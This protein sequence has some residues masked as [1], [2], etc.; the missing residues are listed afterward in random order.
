MN[1]QDPTMSVNVNTT[2]ARA[3]ALP[4]SNGAHK[5]PPPQST[6]QPDADS[7]APGRLPQV[8]REL[9]RHLNTL[10]DDYHAKV[11]DI[12]RRRDEAHSQAKQKL[13]NA[14]K[15]LTKATS[16]LDAW[17]KA[18]EA[19]ANNLQ[20][21][22]NQEHQWALGH[23]NEQS[24]VVPVP[25]NLMGSQP[26]VA[27]NAL[28]T[29]EQR[30][31]SVQQGLLRNLRKI[32]K[33]TNAGQLVKGFAFGGFIL[34]I[35]IAVNSRGGIDPVIG[36]AFVGAI[37]GGVVALV[38]NLS[39]KSN[40]SA[41]FELWLGEKA[42]IE[43]HLTGYHQYLATARQHKQAAA[44]ERY[45]Q[46]K[47]NYEKALEAANAAYASEL[48]GYNR[49]LRP[50]LDKARARCASF[51]ESTAF[52]GLSWSE[53]KWNEWQPATSS[54]FSSCLG[55]LTTPQTKMLQP[56]FSGASLDF[57]VSALLPFADGQDGR[58]LLM[59][60]TGAAKEDATKAIQSVMLRLLANIP[61]GKVLFTLLDPVGL[62][63][64]VA[65]FMPLAD[66]EEKLI[67]SR[68]WTEPQH[69]EE[70]LSKITEHM[71]NVIQKYL[72]NDYPT[73]EEYNKK[74]GEVAEPYRVLVALDF[75][76]N[77]S[78]SAARRLV[79][80][81]RNGPRCGVYTLVVMDTDPSKKS[82]YGFNLADL[83]QSANVIVYNNDGAIQK[84]EKQNVTQPIS[85]GKSK[86]GFVWKDKELERYSLTLDEAP[87]GELFKTIIKTVGEKSKDA[88]KV[89]V[90]FD[91]LLT[92]AG[93]SGDNLWEAKTHDMI[94]VPLGPKGAQKLQYLTFGKGTEHHA[95]VI[96]MPGSGKSNLMHIIITSMAMMYSPEE[97]QLYLIDFK[98]GVEFKRYAE[99]RLPHAK[100]IAIES[101]REFGLSVL[102][103]LDEEL[104]R[105]G[106]N[107]RKLGVNAINEYR[108][109]HPDEKL[110]RILL[111][112]DE[113]QEFFSYDDNIGREANLLL[114]RL[115]RQGR[116]AGIHVM[117][118]SQ[119]LANRSSL[120][121]STL[122]QVGIR[123][124][125]KCSESDARQ[126]MADDNPQ[127]RLLSRSG[128]AIYN[129]ASG[130]IEGNNFFQVAL[131]TDEDRRARL[132][133]ITEF[134]SKVEARNGKAFDRPIIFEGNEPSRL[135]ECAPLKDLLSQNNYPAPKKVKEL[136][137][138]EPVAIRPPTSA[139][140]RQQGASN[141]LIV[142]RNEEEGVGMLA[143]AVISLAAQVHPADGRFIIVDLSTAD[144]SWA[145]L[146][147]DLADMLP[148]Q[149]EVLGRRDMTGALGELVALV[150]H[151][152][153]SEKGEKGE[154][155]YFIVQGLH[156]ARDLREEET[157]GRS[158]IFD[159]DSKEPSAPELFAKLLRE[160]PECGVYVMAWCD[161]YSNVKRTLGRG[162]NEFALRVGG[163]MS[164]DDSMG[165]LDDAVA[166]KLDKPHRAIFFDD[167]RPGQLDKFR[168][169]AIPEKSW[170]SEVA[171][172]LQARV[173]KRQASSGD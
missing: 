136:W 151:R 46:A 71:E 159:R 117:L 152:I 30:L 172:T 75:P 138:G 141:L 156:R 157:R 29:A 35:F 69:I 2:E 20:N 50:L 5:S 57:N 149:I 53:Q 45:R 21:S 51:H 89:E 34:G 87:Q 40:L 43:A 168:P 153:K 80:I 134:A 31:T 59:K 158:S 79:S 6:P 11:A 106:E 101:E 123:I 62:G 10:M 27:E 173:S 160:G 48:H 64:N 91:K 70:Q 74:A 60:A 22:V 28:S 163:A 95:V 16:D 7:L 126:I 18:Q 124:A 66:Y 25:L 164:N 147:E 39:A 130:L 116:Y 33:P 127:A 49:Y 92:Y 114:D 76:T 115:I 122:G 26:V 94:Q 111:L 100:V 54:T 145:E 32:K 37:I 88:M 8:M 19:A 44:Q 42:T 77:F 14:H 140:L 67:N 110:P 129:A 17:F 161:A 12:T 65:P 109:S 113:F 169:Y 36:T 166:S 102:K 142:T 73:I 85:E 98:Q 84:A 146:A 125:L 155:V 1:N 78:D 61:P 162:L 139:R 3:D 97:V 104:Y 132:E 55:M 81:A 154:D 137:L 171:Q 135:E 144:S 128:E 170:L 56:F 63:Q 148:H 103:G 143:S 86:G 13:D 83:E 52:A 119:S 23:L 24:A 118:G 112:V 165:L 4:G 133:G 9:V 131:F 93:I 105:R 58:C 120:P 107:F 99:T 108:K 15:G 47:Q 38:R 82:P 96:G 72:R 150:D 167:E 68:A 90:P 121:S 41:Q